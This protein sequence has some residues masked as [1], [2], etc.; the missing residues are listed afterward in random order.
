MSRTRVVE[1]S[2]QAVAP[3]SI[4][5]PSEAYK[6]AIPE[7]RNKQVNRILFQISFIIVKIQIKNYFFGTNIYIFRG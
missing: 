7:P 6:P 4:S 3:E 1:V 5:P 2:I